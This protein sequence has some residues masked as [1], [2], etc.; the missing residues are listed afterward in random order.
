MIT[1]TIIILTIY[2]M[3]QNHRI[4]DAYAGARESEFYEIFFE[5]VN[6]ISLMYYIN[7]LFGYLCQLTFFLAMIARACLSIFSPIA[8]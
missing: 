8:S 5:L 3:R 4:V 7:V 6:V 1:T 2:M